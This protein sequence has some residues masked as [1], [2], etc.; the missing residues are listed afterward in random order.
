MGRV[1]FWSDGEEELKKRVYPFQ[2]FISYMLQHISQHTFAVRHTSPGSDSRSSTPRPKPT[3]GST[4]FFN[5][6]LSHHRHTRRFPF[7]HIYLFYLNTILRF[8]SLAPLPLLR[9]SPPL[10]PTTSFPSATPRVLELWEVPLFTPV[11]LSHLCFV[12]SNKMRARVRLCA[13]KTSPVFS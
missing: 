10:S 5:S 6:T 8:P 3:I 9:S 11:L 12:A 4:F 7:T 13:G 2:V 1:G